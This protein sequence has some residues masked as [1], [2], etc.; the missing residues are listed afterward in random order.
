MEY[1]LQIEFIHKTKS[2]IPGFELK[3]P[4]QCHLFK[5]GS[6]FKNIGPS[7]ISGAMI[8]NIILRSAN[9]LNI[10]VS[11]DKSFILPNLNPEESTELWFEEIGV[12]MYGLT[13]ITLQIIPSVQPDIIICYQKDHF[14][15]LI[16]KI[17]TPNSWL[18]FFFIES[19]NEHMLNNVNILLL[20]S[21]ILLL[22]VGIMPILSKIGKILW[23]FLKL[24]YQ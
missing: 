18:D 7:P 11:C 15:G 2:I 4:I 6:K 24:K 1:K 23:A 9:G 13:Y 12:Y 10:N 19:K 20:I 3:H 16:T 5:F 17:Q 8:R 21:T 14:S 22:L